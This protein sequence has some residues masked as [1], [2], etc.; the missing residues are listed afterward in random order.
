[1]RIS[2]P[3]TNLLNADGLKR[4]EGIT[5]LRSNR[6]KQEKE[7][8]FILLEQLRKAVGRKVDFESNGML[9]I[10]R[11]DGGSDVVLF[12]DLAKFVGEYSKKMQMSPQKLIKKAISKAAKN[13][14]R[15]KADFERSFSEMLANA[16]RKAAEDE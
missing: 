1:M 5:K 10:H 4:I 3:Y 7:G 13:L 14:E 12:G 15:T 8:S 11:R 2:V 16:E 6:I 9:T